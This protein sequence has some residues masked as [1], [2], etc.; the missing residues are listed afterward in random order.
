MDERLQH[1]ASSRGNAPS[2]KTEETPSSLIGTRLSGI[3]YLADSI[4]I[5]PMT[6]SAQRTTESY[7]HTMT[8][9]R[10]VIAACLVPVLVY[11]CLQT[12][13]A[14]LK[15]MPMDTWRL[16][17]LILTATTFAVLGKRFLNSIAGLFLGG[18]GGAFG[19]SDNFAGPYGGVVGLLVGAI[20]IAIPIKHKP[21]SNNATNEVQA[22]ENGHTVQDGT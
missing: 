1:A 8:V 5:D 2:D 3:L 18:I 21:R 7:P 22:T 13:H 17:P 20:V 12:D 4:A 9:I 19:T 14:R 16:I 11:L 10:F 15:G 6:L